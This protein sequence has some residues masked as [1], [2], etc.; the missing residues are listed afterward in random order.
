[1]NKKTMTA[2]I[3]TAA[4]LFAIPVVLGE[5]AKSSDADSVTEVSDYNEL[6]SAIK[7]GGDVVE[8]RLKAD[9]TEV[10][11]IKIEE[12]KKVT[13]DLNQYNITFLNSTNESRNY[14]EISNGSLTL[15]G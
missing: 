6:L 1:M 13:I 10:P 14:F 5:Y 8:I 9:L 15:T 4:L 3:L 2:V 11:L 7:N 12:D